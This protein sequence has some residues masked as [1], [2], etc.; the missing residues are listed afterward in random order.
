MRSGNLGRRLNLQL[1]SANGLLYA[2][3]AVEVA[4]ALRRGRKWRQ[5][6]FRVGRESRASC[7]LNQPVLD[8][9]Y[10]HRAGLTH[11]MA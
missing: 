5:V 9:R 2:L 4:L 11:L 10:L 1:T 3:C 7:S 6:I 8:D